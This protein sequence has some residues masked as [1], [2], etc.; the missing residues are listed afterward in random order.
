MS[1][2]EKISR[3]LKLSGHFEGERGVEDLAKLVRVLGYNDSQYFGQFQG[4]CI[5][6]LIYFL[7]DNPGAVEAILNW[8]DEN[9]EVEGDEDEVVV[10]SFCDEECDPKTAHMHQGE[11]IGHECCWDERLKASE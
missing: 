9:V 8:I 1:T 2:V 3:Q 10:C 6:D 7:E 4:G 5:G 11:Y